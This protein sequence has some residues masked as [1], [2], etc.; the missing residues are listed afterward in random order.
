MKDPIFEH[1]SVRSYTDQPIDETLL[2]HI[3]EA[4]TRASTTG[5]MQLYSILVTTDAQQKARLAPCHFNQP[6]V[7]Q[8]PVVL[9]FCAD[10][11]RFSAWCR[12]REAHP[13]YD[14]FVWFVNSLIDTTLAA[15][16]VCLSAE[17][18]GLGICYLGTTT[19]NA[20]EIIE[21][22]KLPRGVLPV[23][24]VTLG[25][26]QQMPPLTDRLPLEAVIHREHYQ[27]YTP[28][29]LN[30]LWAAKEQSAET[31]ALLEANQLPN[32]AQIFTER[33]Y[34]AAD[35]LLFSRKYFETLCRQGFFEQDASQQK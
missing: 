18:Q 11:H 22:L 5:N 19:Y 9:T 31:A 3:L 35:N 4:G 14:N 16:N 10:I 20:P 34:T 6:M 7:T 28:E 29:R 25:Y 21:V 30:V 13:Q 15:Q 32:L 26:P 24:T 2:S 17:A 1:R 33:R 23:T 8:A 27:P 12:L